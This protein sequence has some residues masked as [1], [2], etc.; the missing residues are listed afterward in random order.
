MSSG[1]A[2]P[3]KAFTLIELLVVIA[4][5]ALLVAMLLPSL[6][7]A[8]EQALRIQ[9]QSNL[10]QIYNGFVMYANE[11]RDRIPPTGSCATTGGG[12]TRYLGRRGY[13]GKPDLLPDF[14]YHRER[15]P[16]LR[17]PSEQGSV[18]TGLDGTYYDYRYVG[19]SYVMNFYVSEYY[20]DLG[21]GPPGTTDVYRHGLFKGPDR[22]AYPLPKDRADAPLIMD[23]QDLGDGAMMLFYL[24]VDRPDLWDYVG[25]WTGFYYA[26]RHAG[27]TANF[28]YMD[29]HIES[30][31]HMIHGGEPNFRMLWSY[32]TNPPP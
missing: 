24:D 10:R 9:C 28:L 19:T 5:I 17:C 32:P 31:K 27:R 16:V 29:G 20:Y 4:I 23:C 26:F 25:G 22:G 11:F 21:F 1:C 7:R 13:W 14:G 3:R 12:W 8:R 6:R 18:K 2:S 15:W 30:R